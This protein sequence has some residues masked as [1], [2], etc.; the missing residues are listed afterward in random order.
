[1]ILMSKV[2]SAILRKTSFILFPTHGP[3]HKG[4]K[5]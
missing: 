4:I 5:E 2:Q 3:Y 1:M